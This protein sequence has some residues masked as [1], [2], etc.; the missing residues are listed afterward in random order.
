MWPLANKLLNLC[1]NTHSR[2]IYCTN[3]NKLEFLVFSISFYFSAS[4]SLLALFLKCCFARQTVFLASCYRNSAFG[5]RR[6]V[7]PIWASGLDSGT[8]ADLLAGRSISFFPMQNGMAELTC[9]PKRSV[10]RLIIVAQF[11]IYRY[12]RWFG[13]NLANLHLTV[14]FLRLFQ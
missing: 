7:P 4:E 3:L 11:T 8:G 10:F 13:N 1:T 2:I 12:A 5:S 9:T 6:C 14:Y